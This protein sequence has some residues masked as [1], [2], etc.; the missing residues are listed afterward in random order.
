[1]D[2]DAQHRFSGA[3][4]V[5][6]ERRLP[7]RATPAG[8][9]AL[10]GAFNLSVPLPRTLSATGEHHR[11]YED[12]GWRILTPRHA[13]KASVEGHLTFAFKYEGLDLA[14]LKRLFAAVEPDQIAALVRAKP[15]GRY[16]R[17]IWFFYE[18]LMGEQLDLPNA[19][20]GTYVPAV[21]PRKQWAIE[22]EN[23]PR[24]RVKNNLL[25]T[26]AFCPLIFRTERLDEFIEMNLPARAQ[27]VVANVP[28]DLLAR[29]AAFLLLNDSK[30][31]YA[32]EG[33]RAP[34]DRIQRWGRAIREA[35]RQ[36]MD[37][38]E[39]LRLQKIVI[40]DTR[41]VRLGLRKEGGFV[42]EHDRRTRM[43]LPD[44]ISG[45]PDDLPSLMAGMI[46]FDRG[47][48]QKLDAVFAAAVLAF[49]FIY[50]HPFEDGNGRIHRYLI[51]HVLTR[52]GINP[53]GVVFP[54][55]A[56]ILERIDE[57]RRILEG[58]SRRLLPVIKWKPTEDGNV[59]VLNN[60]VDFYRYFDATPHVE[61]LYACVRKTIEEDLPNETE[62]I[63]RYDEFSDRVGNIVDMPD[64]IVDLLFWRYRDVLCANQAF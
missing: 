53:P 55:S 14:V 62:F 23:S 10:I 12:A 33:E 28:R 21:D 59:N 6:H 63:R 51:H 64:R 25:G 54:V 7:E 57:Y 45:R 41:F 31:S 1:M 29:A 27:A 49:G 11:V 5:F 26:P 16:A 19:G 9:S 47:P 37:L 2:S 8:Y 60:T 48:S 40:G 56:A 43:P 34:Q 30:S 35:G 44:H 13:P 38:E 18:W 39:L 61:F 50:I 3:I 36:P 17:R 24:H 4:T 22:G 46:S 42:G 15:T 58:Y 52:R 32:I 20:K